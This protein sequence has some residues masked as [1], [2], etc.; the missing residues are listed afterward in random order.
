[1]TARDAIWGL[2]L[3]ILVVMALA[4][5]AREVIHYAPVSLPIPADPE[6][7]TVDRAELTCLSDDVYAR[8]VYREALIKQDRDSC[9]AIL[10]T[11]RPE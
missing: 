1:M 6:L 8:L 11:T 7:P 2:I 4:G 10:E 9:K 5:C 3:L